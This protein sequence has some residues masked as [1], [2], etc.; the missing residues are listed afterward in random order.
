MPK[1]TLF[2]VDLICDKCLYDS[3]CDLH[4]LAVYFRFLADL[5]QLSSGREEDLFT[6]KEHH[7]KIFKKLYDLVSHNQLEPLALIYRYEQVSNELRKRG[8]QNIERTLRLPNMHNLRLPNR[9]RQA[10]IDNFQAF[11]ELECEDCKKLHFEAF[12]QIIG[13]RTPDEPDF[14]NCAE[15]QEILQNELVKL[16]QALTELKQTLESEIRDECD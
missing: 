12:L 10:T 7:T 14:H 9:I 1:M 4:R 8:K 11:K 2:P 6:L 3:Y 13:L 5:E 15:N 16:D